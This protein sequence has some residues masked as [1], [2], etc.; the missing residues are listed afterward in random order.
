MMA[1]VMALACGNGGRLLDVAGRIF[2]IVVDEE[3]DYDISDLKL[4]GI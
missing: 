2:A 1:V 3:G 4:A